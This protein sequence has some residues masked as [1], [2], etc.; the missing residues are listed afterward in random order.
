MLRRCW[1]SIITVVGLILIV[2]GSAVWV[3]YFDNPEVAKTSAKSKE[4]P[5]N[6]VTKLALVRVADALESI[7]HDQKSPDNENRARRD[8]D[9]QEGAWRWAKWSAWAAF[10]Q[11]LFTVVGFIFV[12]Q[13]LIQGINAERPHVRLFRT[14]KKVSKRNQV[15]SI[16]GV[17]FKNYGRTP[18]LV[19]KLAIQY[20]LAEEPPEP[21]KCKI[22][23]DY[24]DDMVMPQDEEWPRNHFI[25]PLKD[26]SSLADLFP[27]HGQNGKRLFVYGEITYQ[28]AFNKERVTGFCREWDGKN[29]TYNQTDIDGKKNLNYTT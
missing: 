12:R 14:I 2:F 22:I 25:S 7:Q 10:V 18:A 26:Q 29:F 6:P 13:S 9:A 5:T 16:S 17:N 8:L 15:I 4:K 27:L 24:P 20:V 28:D 19:K 23:R 1:Q 21:N 11:I 3:Y